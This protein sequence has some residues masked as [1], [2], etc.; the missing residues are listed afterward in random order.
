MAF[1]IALKLKIP[2]TIEPVSLA[3][4]KLHLRV[5]TDNEDNYI[6]SLITAARQYCEEFQNRAYITQ[7]WE[8]WFD[9]FPPQPWIRLPRPP[10][11]ADGLQVEYFDTNDVRY[12]FTNYFI[13]SVSQPG[14]ISLK[15]GASWPSNTRSINGVCITFKAGYGDSADKV[16]ETIKQA[17]KLLIGHFYEHRDIDTP[18]PRA[19]LSLLWIDRCFL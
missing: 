15:E 19:I 13:D 12:I 18:A 17:I 2:P 7:T 3:D 1:K 14:Y 4:A 16:P 8:L 9:A 11:Q 5:D 6:Q 10:L